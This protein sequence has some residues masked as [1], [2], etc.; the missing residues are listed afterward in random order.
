MLGCASKSLQL[1]LQGYFFYIEWMQY[2]LLPDDHPHFMLKVTT[3]ICNLPWQ[4]WV[5][6]QNWSLGWKMVDQW[7]R[8]QKTN[9]LVPDLLKWYLLRSQIRTLGPI[10]KM[11]L[12]EGHAH[13]L[14][15]PFSL[16]PAP[17][18]LFLLTHTDT[19][20]SC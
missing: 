5:W 4:T 19:P 17:S 2:E 3:I 13:V 16:L 12:H 15:M 8:R 7:T 20:K 6:F 1:R 9:V 10:K 14:Y 11:H 18:H